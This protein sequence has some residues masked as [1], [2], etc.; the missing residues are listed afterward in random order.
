MSR[1]I[2]DWS[3][4]KIAKLTCDTS[5]RLFL[6]KLLEIL[7]QLKKNTFSEVL[8]KQFAFI[9]KLLLLFLSWL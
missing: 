8:K 7:A 4:Y 1:N 5:K 6:Y 9:L 3:F 2:T